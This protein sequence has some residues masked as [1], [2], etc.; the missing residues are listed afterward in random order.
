MPPRSMLHPLAPTHSAPRR[1][2]IPSPGT[3][4]LYRNAAWAHYA[5][6]Y[7]D[8]PFPGIDTQTSGHTNSKIQWRS[9]GKTFVIRN[10]TRPRKLFF[11]VYA[12]SKHV[13]H[14]NNAFE[15]PF[16]C[17]MPPGL[18]RKVITI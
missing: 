18:W 2:S 10:R 5:R 11:N 1:Q 14:Q 8:I 4:V 9:D 15:L 13:V 3:T 7:S 6:S 12:G 16:F 17:L